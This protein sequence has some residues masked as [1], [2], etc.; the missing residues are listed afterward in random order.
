MAGTSA[1]A[2]TVLVVVL[3]PLPSTLG[4]QQGCSTTA[5]VSSQSSSDNAVSEVTTGSASS[6]LD[7][8]V[9]AAAIIRPP[10][11]LTRMRIPWSAGCMQATSQAFAECSQCPCQAEAESKATA[12]AVA[13][14]RALVNVQLSIRG[15]SEVFIQ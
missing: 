12:I 5:I 9:Q 15:G 10:Y 3:L 2:L 1:A 4:Q 13:V 14:A 7:E 11:A 8:C 6:G